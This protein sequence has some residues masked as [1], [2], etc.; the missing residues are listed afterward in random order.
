MISVIILNYNSWKDTIN[1]IEHIHNMFEIEYNSIIVID[2]CSTNESFSKLN[3][4]KN[5]KCITLIKSETNGGY[6]KGNNIGLK[7][8]YDNGYNYALI[9]NNDIEFTDSE[10][11]KKLISCLEYDNTLATVNPDICSPNGKIYNRDSLRPNFFDMSFGM[12]GYIKKGRKL[13][14]INDDYAYVYRPQGCCML[15]D[16][17]KMNDVDYFDENTFLYNEVKA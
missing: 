17:K 11:I 16:L 1:E 12:I 8:A 5:D 15:V 4:F 9:V 2:N 6:A 7:Y 10:T 3:E 14:M 13:K